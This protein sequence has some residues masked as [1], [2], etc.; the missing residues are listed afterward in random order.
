MLTAIGRIFKYG[1]LGFVRNGFVSMA[2]VLVMTIALFMIASSMY[3]DAALKSVLST[4]KSQVDIN[5]YFAP[6][7]DEKSILQL[8]DEL[9]KLSEVKDLR[10]IS[11]DKVLEEFK[12]RHGDDEETMHALQELGDNPFGATLAVR[13]K[14]PSQYEAIA[15]Y[16]TEKMNSINKDQ[17]IIDKVNF[18]DSKKAIDTL[19]NIIYSSKKMAL[20]LIAFLVIV[21]VLIVFNTIRLAIYTNK[22]EISVMK[23]VGASDWYAQGPFIVEGALDGLFSAILTMLILYPTSLYLSAASKAFLGSFDT[24]EY[25]TSHFWNLSAVVFGVGIMLGVVSSYLALKKYLDV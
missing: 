1:T 6:D 14:D 19:N 10:Y 16:I 15:K 22:E 18:T 5:I 2:T 9:S 13:A 24:M 20:G 8:K 25:F 21:A 11:K 12:K 3:A 23:L 7:V 4:L 17:K